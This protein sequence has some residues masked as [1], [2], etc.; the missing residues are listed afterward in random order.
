MRPTRPS[1]NPVRARAPNIALEQTFDNRHTPDM[2][3]TVLIT[4]CLGA[5]GAG[6]AFWL[7]MPA[8]FLTGPAT[9][10]SIAAVSGVRCLIPV[11]IRNTV[12]VVI[13]LALGAGVTPEV[14]QSAAKWPASLIGM[15]L[16]VL[17]IML[18]GAWGL[19][20]L[21]GLDRVTAL[22]S[23]APGHLSFVMGLSLETG[24]NVAMVS[25]IQSLRVLMLTLM[26]PA[27]VALLTDADMSMSAPTGTPVSLTHLALLIALATAT[28]FVFIRLRV[29]AGF[30]LGGMAVSVLGH[31]TGLTP[32]IIPP[33]LSTAAF[34]TMGTLIGTRFTGITLKLILR[35][36]LSAI[37]LTFGGLT[38]VVVATFAITNLV[39]LPF[40][41]VLIALAPGALETMI[42]MSVVVGA[43]STFV[44][45]HHV[46][47]LFVLSF[48]IPVA[49]ASARAKSARQSDL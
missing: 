25:V 1:R 23:S 44:G 9:L 35:A 13:G 8:P 21:F 7:G 11:P 6:L 5:L 28:G 43:D 18:G 29:P 27:S 37:F 49:L 36:S 24:A 30:L 32:G 14:L 22:L 20:R 31:G 26:V 38:V 10:V 19:R 4:F 16:T 47:R 12:F 46:S 3:K 34:I 39:D 15:A 33:A 48:A 41:D 40:L 17:V 42:A 45:F 2:L